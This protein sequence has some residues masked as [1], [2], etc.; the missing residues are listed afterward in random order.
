MAGVPKIL[1]FAGS[2]RKG[3]YNHQLVKVAAA[4][5]GAAGAQVTVASLGDYPM[6]LYD[7]DLE[8]RE[9]LPESVR[10]FK[11]LMKEHDGF[12]IASPE[13]N[14]S[15]TPLLKNVIDWASRPDGD[16]P[17]LACFG[18]KVAALMSAS[19]GALGG[20]R[21][22]RHVREILGNI[23]VLVLPEQWAVGEAHEAF[24]AGGQLKDPARQKNVAGLGEKLAAVLSKLKS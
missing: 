16:E 23:D 11:K 19:P 21:S 2:T 4:G 14:S 13:Y 10:R 17:R 24:D 5:A 15:I 6:P 8:A 22:L 1:A 20:L 7:A 3:S 18:G 9:G 12:L